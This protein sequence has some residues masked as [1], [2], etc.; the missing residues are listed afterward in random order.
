MD[1]G[2]MQMTTPK[3]K[4][5]REFSNFLGGGFLLFCCG[6]VERRQVNQD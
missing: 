2:E 6:L 1:D 4:K 5:K 3:E